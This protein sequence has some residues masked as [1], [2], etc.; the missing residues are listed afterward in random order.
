[1]NRIDELF[2]TKKNKVLSVFFTAGFPKLNDTLSI[3]V[4]LEKSGVDMIEIGIPFSDPVADGPVI[5]ESNKIALDNGMNLRILLEQVKEI[6]KRIKIPIL[7][8]G[9]LNPV[10]QYGI[11]KFCKDASSAGVDGVILPDL[12]LGEFQKEHKAVFELNNLAS[13]FLISP[14]T[15]EQRIREIDNA[16]SGFVY[17]VSSS[18][19][20]GKKVSFSDEQVSYFKK[21]QSLDLKNPIMIGFGISNKESFETACAYSSGAIVGSAFI[22]AIRNS[23]NLDTDINSFVKSI[24]G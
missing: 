24:K 8:M 5:Q 1:M 4:A 20:T 18:S 14:T 16:S 6:R 19:T 23:N 2:K 10:Y 11:E 17:A 3:A 9:Y 13:V 22:N 7:L 21:I 15:S 12:P